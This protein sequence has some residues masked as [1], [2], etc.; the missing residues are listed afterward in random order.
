MPLSKVP[1]KVRDIRMVAANDVLDEPLTQRTAGSQDDSS[2]RGEN[3]ESNQGEN[4]ATDR[5]SEVEK[6]QHV[7]PQNALNPRTSSLGATIAKMEP[8]Q[9]SNETDDKDHSEYSKPE[10][11]HDVAD[12]TLEAIEPATKGDL[13]DERERY[14]QQYKDDQKIKQRQSERLKMGETMLHGVRNN[15]KES[16]NQFNRFRNN[17]EARWANDE[18]RIHQLEE[19]L[20]KAKQQISNHDREQSQNVIQ[21]QGKVQQAEKAYGEQLQRATKLEQAWKKATAALT[22]LR[23]QESSY[24]VDTQLVQ[25]LYNEIIYD[26]SNW[27]SNYCVESGTIELSEE[28]YE[29]VLSM[30][31]HAKHYLSSPKLRPL[32]VQALIMRRLAEKVLNS[33]ADAGLMWA[34]KL[35]T[36]LRAIEHALKYRLREYDT[37]TQEQDMADRRRGYSLWK[38]ATT[39]LVRKEVDEKSV[40]D[41]ID[42]FARHLEAF[43]QPF[44]TEK[45]PTMWNDLQAI[46]S[47]AVRLDEEV[48]K[49]K[50]FFSFDNWSNKQD[51]A[52]IGYTFNESHMESALGF[53]DGREGMVVELLIAPSLMKS[54]TTQG[55]DYETTAFISKWVV[56]CTEH[57]EKMESFS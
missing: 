42:E 45:K 14:L 13:E 20:K 1:S 12:F 39:V 34:G 11:E 48:H 3:R 8:T 57:R 41:L 47:K 19:E 40:I 26:A 16:K 36:D 43:L 18:L 53:E 17:A 30:G 33:S 15:L 2:V 5:L 38:A 51:I 28:Q 6:N 50:A 22:T 54:G 37:S 46:V 23:R 32:L 10:T 49:S 4:N 24:R 44:I 29:Y 31:C 56:V 55:E 52:T 35:G 7:L 9:S 27:A 25:G 21:L